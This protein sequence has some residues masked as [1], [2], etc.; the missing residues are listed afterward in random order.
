[1]AAGGR[2]LEAL[3]MLMGIVSRLMEQQEARYP[4]AALEL[5]ALLLEDEVSRT[6]LGTYVG[7]VRVTAIAQ[8]LKRMRFLFVVL[9]IQSRGLPVSHLPLGFLGFLFKNAACF[10]MR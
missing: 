2:G 6:H 8:M 5:L 7:A 1:M 4:F 9:Q 10:H 3:E